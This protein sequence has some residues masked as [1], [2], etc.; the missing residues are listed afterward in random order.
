VL[1]V[2]V[3]VAVVE[4]VVAAAAAVTLAAGGRGGVQARKHC[5]AVGWLVVGVGICG[6]GCNLLFIII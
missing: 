5:A 3:V 6:G 1:Q 4:V 2:V